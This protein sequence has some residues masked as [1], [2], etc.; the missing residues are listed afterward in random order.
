M[1][2]IFSGG[3]M[4]RG[5]KSCTEWELWVPVAQHRWKKK[6]QHAAWTRVRLRAPMRTWLLLALLLHCAS[7]LQ[8]GQL[9][10]TRRAALGLGAAA[11]ASPLA[12]A[13]AKT[14]A[15]LNPNKQDGVGAGA[16]A[17]IKDLYKDEYKQ[18]KGDK[19]TRGTDISK[20]QAKYEKLRADAKVKKP[21]TNANRTPDPAALGL[22]Q[23][24]GD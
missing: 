23:W 8:L 20:D 7:A 16:G 12:P 19:G 22:K 9:S 6:K 3:R 5:L 13:S 17:Y 11:L 2:K 14:K 24:S 10:V 18:I 1:T 21:P 15:S 4:D